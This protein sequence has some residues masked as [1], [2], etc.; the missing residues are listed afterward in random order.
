MPNQP[1]MDK[2]MLSVRL[3]RTDFRKL[4]KIAEESGKGFNKCVIGLLQDAAYEVPLTTE[5]YE[6]IKKE[7]EKDIEK[8]I[9]KGRTVRP[10]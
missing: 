9:R 2:R 10:R 8:L 1:D 3:P 4:Q 6:I 5:D 7:M